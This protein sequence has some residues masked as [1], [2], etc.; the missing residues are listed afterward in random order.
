M[1]K[2]VAAARGVGADWTADAAHVHALAGPHAAVE[3]VL[4]ARSP[5]VW[6]VLVETNDP[7]RAPPL[8]RVRG[9]YAGLRRWPVDGLLGPESEIDLLDWAGAAPADLPERRAEAARLLGIPQTV[10]APA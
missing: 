5:A 10:G 2:L 7:Y 3:F 6:A 8:R 4:D 9:S 1:R